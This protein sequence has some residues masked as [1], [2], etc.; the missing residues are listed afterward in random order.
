MMKL[1]QKGIKLL[2]HNH[3]ELMVQFLTTFSTVKCAA[4]MWLMIYPARNNK[5]LYPKI[6]N[7]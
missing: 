7:L 4:T 2:T 3:T 1:R 5:Q 6:V